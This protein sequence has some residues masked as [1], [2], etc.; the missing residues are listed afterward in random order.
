[1]TLV[2]S[3]GVGSMFT[4]MTSDER[5]VWRV[6]DRLTPIDD[7]KGPKAYKLNELLLFGW[8]GNS[9]RADDI[10]EKLSAVIEPGDFLTECKRK[11]QTVVDNLN[12]SPNECAVLISGFYD[13]GSTGMLLY[14]GDKTVKELRQQPHE[15]RYMM[16]PPTGD[17]S[18]RQNDYFRLPELQEDIEETVAGMDYGEYLQTAINLVV[19]KLVNVHAMISYKQSIEVSSE[20]YYYVLYRG[21]DGSIEFMNG[22]YD[23]AP[24]HAQ[25]DE[26]EN[27]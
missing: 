22:E 21:P 27:N 20:G 19:Q 14:R 8:G 3:A 18:D 2:M 17:Y 13:D 1:M 4:V 9:D 5:L 15:Y 10:R 23:T 6:G 16:L 25:L 26:L 7:E 12:E 24:V 11:L